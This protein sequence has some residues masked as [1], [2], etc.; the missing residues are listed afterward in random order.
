MWQKAVYGF[1]D[2][3]IAVRTSSFRRAVRL[4]SVRRLATAGGAG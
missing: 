2:L 4:L 3:L 1:G